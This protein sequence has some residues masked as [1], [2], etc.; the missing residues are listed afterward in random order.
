VYDSVTTVESPLGA[1]ESTADAGAA[2]ATDVT[3]VEAAATTVP[4][5]ITAASGRPTT[6]HPR[7]AAGWPAKTRRAITTEREMR[8]RPPALQ[9]PGALDFTC[10]KVAARPHTVNKYAPKWLGRTICA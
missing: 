3:A 6:L 10:R 8:S 7:L 2:P 5:R 4:A 9:C 1:D